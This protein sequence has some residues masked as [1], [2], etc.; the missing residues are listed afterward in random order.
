MAA[1]AHEGEREEV[2]RIIE[3]LLAEGR[4]QEIVILVYLL[5]YPLGALLADLREVV[6]RGKLASHR[7]TLSY[8]MRLKEMGLI[9]EERLRRS[10]LFRLTE[11]GVEVA[12]A[13][14]DLV[15]ALE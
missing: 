2:K 5:R 6:G 1:A 12:R 9:K 3:R 8:I 7:R 4:A 14:S 11:K 15:G 13:L 10:R